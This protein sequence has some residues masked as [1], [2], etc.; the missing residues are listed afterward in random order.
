MYVVAVAVDVP[1]L[2]PHLFAFF[3]RA[4]KRIA[5]VV[6]VVAAVGPPS[7]CKDRLFCFRSHFF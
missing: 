3:W 4:G 2:Y 1:P 7:P 5:P 6:A